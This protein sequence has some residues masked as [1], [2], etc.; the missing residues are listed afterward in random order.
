M[1]QSLKEHVI[2]AE[3]Q[4]RPSVVLSTKQDTTVRPRCQ[5]QQQAVGVMRSSPS[6]T[7]WYVTAIDR[8]RCPAPHCI[9]TGGWWNSHERSKPRP[10]TAQCEVNNASTSTA[11]CQSLTSSQRRPTAHCC[12]FILPLN[13]RTGNMCTRGIV[14]KIISRHSENSVWID[15][16]EQPADIHRLLTRH[17]LSSSEPKFYWR[18]DS[19]TSWIRGKYRLCAL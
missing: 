13:P 2:L 19:V 6:V 17:T 8:A 5:F 3:P 9:Y 16:M 4:S 12:Y 11:K 7:S 18:L 15:G 14:Y 10:C 1:S